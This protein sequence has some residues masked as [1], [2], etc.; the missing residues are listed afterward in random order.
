MREKKNIPAA[1]DV[2]RLEPLL[3]LVLLCCGFDAL[4]WPGGGGGCVS[5]VA[6]APIAVSVNLKKIVMR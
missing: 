1:R 6:A 2:S 5:R 3:L 4:R